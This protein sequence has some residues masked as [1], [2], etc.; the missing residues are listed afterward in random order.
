MKRAVLLLWAGTLLAAAQPLSRPVIADYAGAIREPKPRAD[1]IRHVDTPAL[2]AKLK[3]LGVNTYVYLIWQSPSD[4]DDLRLEFLPAAQKA[5]INVWAYLVPPSECRPN[6]SLPFEQ[7]YVRWGEEL[8]KL[9]LSFPNLEAWAIDDFNYNFKFFTPEYLAKM[10]EASKRINPRLAFLPQLYFQHITPEFLKAY[11]PVIDGVI[12]AFR[13]DPYRNT[14]ITATIREQLD[15]TSELLKAHNRALILMIY[16]ARLSRAEA[17]PSPEYLRETVGAGLEYL[18]AGRIAGVCTYVLPK[19]PRPEPA[20]LNRAHSGLGRALISVPGGVK[21]EAGAYAE[22][23]AAAKPSPA[24]SR[25]ISF[26]VRLSSPVASARRGVRFLQVL[27]NGAVAG[28]WDVSEWKAG[29]WTTVSTGLPESE[30]ERSGLAFRLI[31]KAAAAAFPID[32]SIDSIVPS[33]FRIA[34]PGF[35]QPRDWK[36]RRTHPAFLPTIDVFDPDRPA[37]CYEAVRNLFTSFRS[38]LT[39]PLR[40]EID[41]RARGQE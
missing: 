11:A 34:D 29:E 1:G 14:L 6:C 33:G 23:V 24:T 21:T 26:Q 2:L 9:S 38:R 36:I 13:D 4:W 18:K 40:P 37:R 22:I 8:A 19:D 27:W 17:P 3:E 16:A 15:R 30:E 20:S 39:D 12:F 28:E 7:D 10:R 31:D 25:A 5:E 32:L 41:I 35:E